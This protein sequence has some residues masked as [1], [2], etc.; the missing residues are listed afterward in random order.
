[1]NTSFFIAVAAPLS[2]VWIPLDAEVSAT[3]QAWLRGRQ[4]CSTRFYIGK[5]SEMFDASKILTFELPKFKKIA[6]GWC[7]IARGEL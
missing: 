6:T 3:L 5:L 4:R 1:M 2:K 7:D